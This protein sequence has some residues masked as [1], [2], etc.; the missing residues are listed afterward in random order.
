MT[1]RRDW[2]YWQLSF[3]CQAKS[4]IYKINVLFSIERNQ[5]AAAGYLDFEWPEHYVQA[6][7]IIKNKTMHLSNVD[8]N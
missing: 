3:F 7:F 8:Q 4:T 2:I 6:Q 5:Y 1:L